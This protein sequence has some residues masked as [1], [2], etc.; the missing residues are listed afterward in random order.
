[1]SDLHQEMQFHPALP[2]LHDGCFLGALPEQRRLGMQRLE[3]PA[4]R[5]RLAE[6]RAIVELIWPRSTCSI[7]TV[8]PFSARKILT[9]RGFGAR[10]PS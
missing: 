6:D 7:G 3:V 9:R 4:D 5:N 10:P 2:H 8:R 1:M